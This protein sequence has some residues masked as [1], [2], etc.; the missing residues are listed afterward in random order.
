MPI[1]NLRIFY[2]SSYKIEQHKN[3]LSICNMPA[4][5]LTATHSVQRK[6]FDFTDLAISL[7]HWSIMEPATA[8]KYDTKKQTEKLLKM[9]RNLSDLSPGKSVKDKSFKTL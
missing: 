8:C 1:I 4:I 2:T 3:R 5:R 7:P 9:S 6:L